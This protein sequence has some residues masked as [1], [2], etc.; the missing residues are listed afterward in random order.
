MGPD[1][2][3]VATEV[4]AG[5]TVCRSQVDSG[6]GSA[7]V[8]SDEGTVSVVTCPLALV[9]YCVQSGFPK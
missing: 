7:Y 4:G 5:A 6:T 1:S 2:T 3:V 9:W 8:S